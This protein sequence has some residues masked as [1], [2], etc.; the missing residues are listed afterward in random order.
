MAEK[1][2]Q[3]HLQV[4]DTKPAGRMW[5]EVSFLSSQREYE[6]MAEGTHAMTASRTVGEGITSEY[7]AHRAQQSRKT[8]S[9]EKNQHEVI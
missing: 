4:H 2:Q 1:H 8:F 5:T 7:G 9:E 6:R 3:W